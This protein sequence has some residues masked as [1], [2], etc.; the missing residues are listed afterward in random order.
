MASYWNPCVSTSCPCPNHN[1]PTVI[2]T[3]DDGL[4]GPSLAHLATTN[5]VPSQQEEAT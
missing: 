5:D 3:T 2:P 4:N 1:I